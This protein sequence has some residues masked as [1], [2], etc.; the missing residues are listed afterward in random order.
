MLQILQMEILYIY[1]Y[2]SPLH[3][4]DVNSSLYDLYTLPEFI[5]IYIYMHI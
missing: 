5:Y 3:A 2:I 1:M 4:F